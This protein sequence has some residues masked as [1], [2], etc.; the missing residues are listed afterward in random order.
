MD[1]KPEIPLKSRERQLL[2]EREFSDMGAYT[3]TIFISHSKK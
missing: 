2:A 1:T 3:T